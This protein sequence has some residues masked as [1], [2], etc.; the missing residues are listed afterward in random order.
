MGMMGKCETFDKLDPETGEKI[1]KS[2]VSYAKHI[3][4]IT[5]VEMEELSPISIREQ[6]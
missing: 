4:S 1:M 2:K 3:I 6:L 5:S